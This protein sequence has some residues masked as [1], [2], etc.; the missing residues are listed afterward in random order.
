ME[1]QKWIKCSERMPEVE[2]DY[3]VLATVNIHNKTYGDIAV[4]EFVKDLTDCD[5][6]TFPDSHRPGFLEQTDNGWLIE[7]LPSYWMEL[8]GM[9]E[10]VT[11]L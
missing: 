10:G 9:P 1:R 2:K 7:V 8:P 5:E 11:A 6:F 4:C 3:L